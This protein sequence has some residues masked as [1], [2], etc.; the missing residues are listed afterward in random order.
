M[1]NGLISDEQISASSEWDEDHAAIQGR[2]RFE[3]TDSKAGSWVVGTTDTNQWLQIDLDSLNAIVTRV[4]TQRRGDMDEWV[5]NYN[6]LYGD[7]GVNF[8]NYRE[9]GDTVTKVIYCYRSLGG[10]NVL[11]LL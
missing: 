4:A 7:D 11:N 2:L 6:L 10:R 1:E 5:A 9:D 8:Q 3:P